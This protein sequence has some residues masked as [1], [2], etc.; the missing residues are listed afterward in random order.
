MDI[1]LSMIGYTDQWVYSSYSHTD[2]NSL[3]FRL[4]NIINNN[5]IFLRYLILI[6]SNLLTQHLNPLIQPY[7]L[8]LQLLNFPIKLLILIIHFYPQKSIQSFYLLTLHDT[9]IPL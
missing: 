3:P 4:L 8:T 7:L 2:N 9:I 6:H 1:K 5:P